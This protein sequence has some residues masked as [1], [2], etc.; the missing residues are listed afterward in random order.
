MEIKNSHGKQEHCRFLYI[1]SHSKAGL[2]RMREL[3]MVSKHRFYVT[4][5]LDWIS[6]CEHGCCLINPGRQNLRPES[7]LQSVNGTQHPSPSYLGSWLCR[8]VLLWMLFI[9]RY[10]EPP[11]VTELSM[12]IYCVIWLLSRV[13]LFCDPRDLRP[14]GF[15][16]HGI[17]QARILK[18]VAISFSRES[19]PPRNWTWVSWIGRRVLYC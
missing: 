9:F 13:W 15:Y 1:F 2:Q 4:Y 7:S 10:F 14:P 18:W 16:I 11:Q 5:S 8:H 17:S 6:P 12:R 19:S 3:G